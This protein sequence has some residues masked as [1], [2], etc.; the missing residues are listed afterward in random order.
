MRLEATTRLDA[1][2]HSKV[3]V[4]AYGTAAV[5]IEGPTVKVNGETR[6]LSAVAT[7]IRAGRSRQ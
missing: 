3:L 5:D 6:P 4:F 2:G 1:D 7:I